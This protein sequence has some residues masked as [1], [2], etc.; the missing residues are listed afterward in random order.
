VHFDDTGSFLV[1]RDGREI[2]WRPGPDPDP[3]KVR[4][5][6]LGPVLAAA[7]HAAGRFCLHGSA[8][9][10]GK[11]A[12]ALLGPKHH[13]KSTLAL[14]LVE[15]GARLLTDDSLPVELAT[16]A[17]ALPGVHSVRVWDDSHRRFEAAGSRT[18][19]GAG[20]KNVLAGLPLASLAHDPA[21]LGAVYLL[22][23]VTPEPGA[24]AARREAL[25]ATMASLALVHSAKIGALAGRSEAAVL[26]E[27]ATALAE[28]VPVYT[29]SVARDFERL[30][31]VVTQLFDWH[32]DGDPCG[33]VLGAA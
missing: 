17:A 32:G 23:P 16:P 4:A 12:L 10:L 27:R 7:Q 1:D 3:E 11:T 22:R 14:A 2:R 8:V 9:T 28:Q 15:R 13:G 20:G 24:A 30:D 5:D 6:V 31:D 19:T 29:L 21:P 26:L 25:P 33:A 18:L